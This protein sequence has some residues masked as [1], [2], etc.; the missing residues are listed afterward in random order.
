MCHPVSCAAF[1]WCGR[2]GAIRRTRFAGW[3]IAAGLAWV[4]SA[5]QRA[6]EVPPI[7]ALSLDPALL[8]VLTNARQAVLSA[9]R[10][11]EAW[12]RLGQAWQAAEFTTE[13][14]QCY[15]R[16]CELGPP[17]PRWFHLLGLLQLAD[18]PAAGINSLGR[19]AVLAGT[20]PDAP[21][22]CLAQALGERGRFDEA[23][24]HL[25]L[26]LQAQPGHAAARLE[27][28]RAQLAQGAL[29]P[30]AETLSVCL[31]NAFT[32]RSALLLL[33]QVRQRQGRAAEADELAR[34]AGALPRPFAW[35]DPYQ[36]EV[37]RLRQDR[38]VLAEMINA[39]LQQR[40]FPEADRFLREA[41]AR[42]PNDPELLLL[43]GR[44]LYQQRDCAAAEGTFR[45]LLAL[46]PGSV[47][48][49]IQLAL[50][51]LCLQHWPDAVAALRQAVALK[52]DFAQAHYNLGYALA[53]TGDAVGAVGSYREALRCSPGDVAAHVALA[54]EL[55]RAGQNAEAQEHLTRALE[56]NPQDP[57]ARQLQER[58][59]Q[60]R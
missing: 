12:G 50:A 38:S 17:S 2:P 26:L 6:P 1:V 9:P 11:A 29:D 23:A 18:D 8:N 40:R 3:L 20:T 30:A 27:L 19:A 14:R 52:P 42:Y 36:L 34:Q 53:K 57:R 7:P 51:Q 45:Q 21:R 16:A 22:V 60:K 28:A 13:A 48:T 54:D 33:S 32:A 55:A 56:L 49:L 37:Q 58:W 4:M 39:Q 59:Q 25:Q 24:P 41:L 47:N 5:C 31:T 43:Q 15:L 44:L 10:S 46:Q 35:P